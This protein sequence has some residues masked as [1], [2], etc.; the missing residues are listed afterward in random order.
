VRVLKVPMT[1]AAAPYGP[2]WTMSV[3]ILA[4]ATFMA[5]GATIDLLTASTQ[6]DSTM[7]FAGLDLPVG[8]AHVAL[9]T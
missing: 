4:E 8:V 6:Y 1:L 2:G 7:Q 3:T 9:Q 5:P